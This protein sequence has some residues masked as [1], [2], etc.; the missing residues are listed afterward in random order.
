MLKKP[1]SAMPTERLEERVILVV[2]DERSI[3]DALSTSLSRQG[4]EVTLCSD[5]SSALE[6]FRKLRH[7]LVLTDI[8]MPGITGE[9]LLVQI[10]EIDA[11]TAVVMMTGYGTI[12]SAVTTIKAGAYDY[13]VKPFRI[14]ELLH[15][16][17]KAW[18]HRSLVREKLRLQEN[19]LHVLRAM[20]N[21]LE[22]RDAYTAGHSQR[23]TEIALAIAGQL[24][25]P[26]EE[27]AVLEL[28]GPIHDIG[29]IGI[30]DHILRKPAGLSEEEYSLIKT[31]PEKGR[32]II[33]P[34]DF[35]KDTI[36]IIL[37]HHEH[38]DGQG[39]PTGLAGEDIPLGARII[40]VADSYDAMT[41]QR[42][43]R[44][45]MSHRDAGDELERCRNTQ[46]DP[47]IVDAFLAAA[48]SAKGFP[49]SG[50]GAAAL[51]PR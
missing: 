34:L 42:A 4:Y 50:G 14:E 8:K 10:K 11:T 31:H 7:P 32:Q 33:E 35:L 45:A 22:Q 19:S 49:V 17:E 48:P 46:F 20:V 1:E 2:D 28:A 37:H 36:P 12:D 40:T 41:S 18:S 21:V 47:E 6:S 25:R 23:V 44:R 3:L 43:Y 27:L 26:R 15:V 24:G 9:E 16:L 51:A 29:K 5:G 13:I 39:Y 30:E 38:F